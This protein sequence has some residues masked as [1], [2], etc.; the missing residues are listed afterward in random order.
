MIN[1][2]RTPDKNGR[3]AIMLGILRDGFTNEDRAQS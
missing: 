3:D 2:L 1:V